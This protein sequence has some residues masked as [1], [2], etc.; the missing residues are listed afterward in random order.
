[1]TTPA[2]V[3]EYPEKGEFP[4]FEQVL[5]DLLTPLSYT[6]TSLPAEREEL[7]ALIADGLIWVRRTGGSANA[8]QTDDRA[9][10]Q[11]SVITP[12]RRTSQ[13]LARH[14]RNAVSNCPGKSIN[15]VLIDYVEETS[16][17]LE[18][19]ELDPLNREIEVG[20]MMQARKQW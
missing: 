10:V 5:V 16:G 15:G 18:Q 6:C 13:R 12:K 3:E 4:D 8:D 14:V 19:L 17:A 11:L 20:F 7:D 9:L 1:M 2:E